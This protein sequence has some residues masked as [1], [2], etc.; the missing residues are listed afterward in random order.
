MD[1]RVY[2]GTATLPDIHG[3][4]GISLTGPSAAPGGARLEQPGRGA[5]SGSC[6]LP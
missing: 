4:A 6:N 5:R 2:R 1:H 3:L